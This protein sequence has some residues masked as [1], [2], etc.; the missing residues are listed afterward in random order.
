MMIGNVN[1]TFDILL[2]IM[3]MC[4]NLK[5]YRIIWNYR[6]RNIALSRFELPEFTSSNIPYIFGII[7]NIRKGK[8]KKLNLKYFSE[9]WV[10]TERKWTQISSDTGVGNPE[11]A[12]KEKGEKYFN[13]LTEKIGD[14]FFDLCKKDIEYIDD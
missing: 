7:Y 1:A 10:W 6:D 14:L 9:K 2:Y 3:I 4:G 5:S 13:D 11:L 8:V 12:S